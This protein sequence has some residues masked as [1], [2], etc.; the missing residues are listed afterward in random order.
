MTMSE[1]IYGIDLGTSNCLCAK[2]TKLFGEV[3]IDCLMDDEGHNSFPSVVYFASSEEVIVGDKAKQLLPDF[4]E[5]TVELVKLTLGKEKEIRIETEKQGDLKLSPQEVTAL[6]LRHFNQ[7]HEN[8]IKKAI[9]T[10]P[11]YFDDNEKSATLQAGELAGIEII[12]LIEEPSAAIMYHL[13][14]KYE[15][16]REKLQLGDH[17]KNYLVFD[18][19]G[20]TLDLSFIKVEL[21]EDGDIRPNV[22]IKEGDSELGGNLIDLEFT[23]LV[24]EILEENYDDLFL[25]QVISEF[26]YYYENQKFKKGIEQNVKEFIMRLKNTLENAKIELSIKDEVLIEFGNLN[27]ENLPFTRDEFETDI[28]EEFFRD[29]VIEILLKIK[30]KNLNNEAIHEVV[31]VGG[32]SQIP[33]FKKLISN[34]FP[35]LKDNLVISK[36]YDN[37]VAKGAAILGAIKSGESIPPFG[38]NRCYNIVSHDILVNNNL[39][40][41]FGTQFPL[42]E[43]KKLLFTIR[44]A[45]Q[46]NINI[47]ISE[48]YE[49]YDPRVKKRILQK[50]QIKNLKFFHP[51]FYTGDHLSIGL[52]INEHGLL[53][54]NATHVETSE[55]IEFESEKFY[56]LTKMDFKEAQNKLENIRDKS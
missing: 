54:F 42:A 43:P 55:K 3:E 2:A 52:D 14:G 31:L 32:T 25:E 18:F 51:F 13:F 39:I 33:Y 7:L 5:R 19:G 9:L 23:K 46:T 27:Y 49:K 47:D 56:N 12:E 34:H 36:D 10:V 45:L 15:K 30:E 16:V 1:T 22:L 21:D 40:L 35:E 37:A 38:K 29:R 26:E 24:L 17:Y 11:A 53:F 41:P 50:K 4:P 8:N 28:L 20:G 48:R 6:L 44:H